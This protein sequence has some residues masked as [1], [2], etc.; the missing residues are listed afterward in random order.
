M[1]NNHLIRPLTAVPSQYRCSRP[2]QLALIDSSLCLIRIT[3]IIRAAN[4]LLLQSPLL[5]GGREE[6]DK[7]ISRINLFGT[8][9][10]RYAVVLFSASSSLPPPANDIRR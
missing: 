7:R 3:V 1:H 5:L 2:Y 8:P 9:H 4:L 10:P 6:K